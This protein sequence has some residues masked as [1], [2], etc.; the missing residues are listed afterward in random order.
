[1]ND[2]YRCSKFFN[3][4]ISK[5]DISNDTNMSY[6]FLDALS[7]K[8]EHPRLKKD[9]ELQQ[10]RVVEEKQRLKKEKELQQ[11]REAEERRLRE[12]KLKQQREAEERRLREL[13]FQQQIEAEERRK[14]EKYMIVFGIIIL[15]SLSILAIVRIIFK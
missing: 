6:M 5:W 13:E 10:Q 11:Q 4:Q 9:K 1:M 12:K 14:K 8:G 3:Q 2:M 7:F 15:V